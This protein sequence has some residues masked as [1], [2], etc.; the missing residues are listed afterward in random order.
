M[1]KTID[2]WAVTLMLCGVLFAAAIWNADC[3]FAGGGSAGRATEMTQLANKAQLIK[4]VAQSIEQTATL[5][6]QYEN[7]LLN[8]EK[9]ESDT[10]SDATNDLVK[11]RN[12]LQSAESL[13]FGL[14]FDSEKFNTRYPGYRTE[15]ETDYS[16]LYKDRVVDWQK[17][18]LAALEVNQL[19]AKRIID[20]QAFLGE[21]HAAASSAVGQNQL[22]QA[23]NQ[24]AVYM[25]QQMTQLRL[26][27][28]RQIESQSTYMLDHKQGE[29]DDHS[30]FEAAVGTWKKPSTGKSY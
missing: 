2:K 14:S 23:G 26:D 20:Q 19:E 18:Y 29:A 9:L 30:A 16:T 6:K 3:A 21:L 7:M 13:T 15:V 28:Q 24:I 1:L 25:A 27:M 8:T 11:L 22:I 5:L 4:Q 17:Y 12:L 10:W